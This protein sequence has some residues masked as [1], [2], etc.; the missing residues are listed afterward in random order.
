MSLYDIYV[1]MLEVLKHI[2]VFVFLGLVVIVSFMLWYV[3]KNRNRLG[4]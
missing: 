3:D 1:W 4:E 2:N